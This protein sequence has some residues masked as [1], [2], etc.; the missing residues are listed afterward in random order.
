MR[1]EQR[2]PGLSSFI[3]THLFALVGI[4]ASLALVLLSSVQSAQQVQWLRDDYHLSI[5]QFQV[6]Y[7]V[8]A[9]LFLVV[10]TFEPRLRTRLSHHRVVTVVLAVALV[11]SCGAVLMLIPDQPHRLFRTPNLLLY[12]I[13]HAAGMSALAVALLAPSKAS[14]RRAGLFLV[15]L[16]LI[17]LIVHIASVGRFAPLNDVYDEAYLASGG[18]NYAQTGGISPAFTGSAYGDPDPALARFYVVMGLWLR[19]IDQTGMAAL[20][21]FSLLV[22]LVAALLTLVALLHERHFSR[23]QRITGLVVLLGLS[24]FVRTSHNVRMDVGL[25]ACSALMLVLLLQAWRQPTRTKRFLF[26]AGLGLY[27]GLESVPTVS[28]NYGVA[29]GIGVVVAAVDFKARRLDWRAVLSYTAGAAIACTVYLIVHYLPDFE[30]NLATMDDFTRVYVDMESVV[31]GQIERLF[32]FIR[33]SATL[34]PVEPFVVIGAFVVALMQ[35][36]REPRLVAFIALLALLF[37]VVSIGGSYGYLAVLAPLVAYVAASAVEQARLRA[38]TAF[39]L[40][41]AMIIA[42]LYDMTTML[43]TDPN[44]QLLSELA[45]ARA[46]VADDAKVVGPDVFWFALYDRADFI[47]WNGVAIYRN[48][49]QIPETAALAELAPDVMI[50]EA[51]K[52]KDCENYA[53][54][55][56]PMVIETQDKD[57]LLYVVVE[58]P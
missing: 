44:G 28:L 22:G 7:G 38:V 32:N 53:P 39:V 10:G 20:R 36:R 41:P 9:A 15:G 18:T 8:L 3:S 6:V 30:A 23:F 42:P 11:V 35:K 21:S 5:G 47:G 26:L 29:V 14:T 4:V 56:E 33:M 51:T 58:A 12:A 1:P 13:I 40:L 48:R 24:T 37:I 50:C 31:A 55:V 57:Y 17:L 27:I 52:P 49:K 2:R 16:A 43:V 45:A 54:G 25:A 34:S 19:L 46:Y